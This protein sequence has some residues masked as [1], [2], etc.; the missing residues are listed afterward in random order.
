MSKR[1]CRRAIILAVFSLILRTPSSRAQDSC[2]EW[3][4]GLFTLRG[5]ADSV[6]ALT[7]FNDGT[8]PALYAGGRFITAGGVP[9]NRIAKWNGSAWSALGSG[10]SCCGTVLDLTVFD[11]GTGPAL[12]AGG[13][14]TTAGGAVSRFIAE[15]S[16]MRRGAVNAGF[17]PVT[18]VLFVNDSPGDSRRVVTVGISQPVSLSLRS[19]PGGPASARNVVWLWPRTPANPVDL[20]LGGSSLGCLVNPTPVNQPMQPQPLVCLR[21]GIPVTACTGTRELASPGRAPWTLMRN[22][23]SSRAATFTV[24]GVVEDGGSANILGFSATNA[25]ILDVR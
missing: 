4:P 16:S 18:D 15:W 21:S 22:R 7:V 23:G 19:A 6:V 14:F 3:V 24:Q 20:R 1:H 11:D 9:A 17:G 8:G 10:M 13:Y 12:Y 25:V 5:V 2:H